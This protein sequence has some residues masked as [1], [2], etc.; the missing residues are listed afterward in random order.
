MLKNDIGE[1][2]INI[3]QASPLGLVTNELISNSLKYAFPDERKGEITVS[4]KKLDRELELT[5]MDD[6]VGI[7]DSFD[8]K[9][10]KSL[11]L[12]LVRTSVENQLDGS[13]DMESNNGTKFTIRFNLEDGKGDQ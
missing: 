9:N 3:N 5:V 6:G 4:I 11:G 2:P 1:M 7:P 12:K 13:I 10:S 8:W